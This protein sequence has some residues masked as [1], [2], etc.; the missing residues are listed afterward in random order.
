MV[1]KQKMDT[2]ITKN[3]P[4]QT[5]QHDTLQSTMVRQTIHSNRPLFPIN[6]K[7]PQLR[8]HT[9]KNTTKHTRMDMPQMQK[10][11][12]QRHQR[13]NKYK[14]RRFKNKIRA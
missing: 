5:N 7:M 4:I 9:R 1:P 14:K 12:P 11:P 6:K 10:T 13:R 3:Q 2:Q 8:T